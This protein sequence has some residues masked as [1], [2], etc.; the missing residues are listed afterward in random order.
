MT[1]PGKEGTDDL[2][3]SQCPKKRAG[4]NARNLFPFQCDNRVMRFGLL[5]VAA[6]A[7][8]CG[9]MALA[10]QAVTVQQLRDF[11]TSSI[12][13]KQPDKDVAATLASMKM[14]ERL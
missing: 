10:Q 14:S 6:V 12:S 11:I 2:R 3:L 8:V 13:Q 7:C 5:R 9:A 1:F 4:R